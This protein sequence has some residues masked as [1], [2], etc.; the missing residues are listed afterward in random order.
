MKNSKNLS[1]STLTSNT[2]EQCAMLYTRYAKLVRRKCLF[3]LR[4]ET[5][6]E[7]ATHDIFIKIYLHLA[8][9]QAR[10]NITTWIYSITY[11]HCL[12][13]L[14][15]QQKQLIVSYYAID[16][17]EC[18][19]TTENYQIRE[20]QLNEMEFALNELPKSE[21]NILLLKYRE[22]KTVKEIAQK[23]KTSESAMKMRL[24]RA[25]EHAKSQVEMSM[26]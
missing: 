15:K 6:A 9:F 1:E 2:S 7:D 21:R 19:D 8:A 25:R 12:D 13:I 17:C 10:A 16:E 22:G 18:A 24:K 14:R 5:L 11:N 4:N 3:L 20:Y 23:M 26:A